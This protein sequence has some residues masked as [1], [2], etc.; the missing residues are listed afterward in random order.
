MTSYTPRLLSNHRLCSYSRLFA[1]I[2]EQTILSQI[3]ERT[4]PAQFAAAKFSL[5]ALS[6]RL[7]AE[8][9]LDWSHYPAEQGTHSCVRNVY[10]DAIFRLEN[11]IMLRPEPAPQEP[12]APAPTP[13]PV[14]IEA[15]LVNV[16]RIIA[17]SAKET[18]FGHER[19]EESR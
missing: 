5:R 7:A 3:T 18:P 16:E 14:P 9:K 10:A 4:T 1:Q 2:I 6:E 17:E 12:S 19:E 13:Q 11:S 15:L 8:A